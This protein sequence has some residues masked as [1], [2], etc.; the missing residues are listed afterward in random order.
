MGRGSCRCCWWSERGQ[1]VP[2]SRGLTACWSSSR[3]NGRGLLLVGEDGANPQQICSARTR[4]AGARNPVW[5]PDGSEIA[6]SVRHQ[7]S[8]IYADGSCFACSLP[9][10]F[11][12]NG[13]SVPTFDPGFLPDGRLVV[14]TK[15]DDIPGSTGPRLAAMMTDGANVAQPLS[16]LAAAGVVRARTASRRPARQTQVSGVRDRSPHREGAPADPRWRQLAELVTGW[17]SLGGRRR[18]LD[19]SGLLPR[20]ATQAPD[21]R[22]GARMGAERQRACVRRCAPP[23]VRDHRPG[24]SAPRRRSHS[25]RAG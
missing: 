19:C 18:W 22:R 16:L 20:E 7:T 11:D 6:A 13:N 8:V 4:C 10:P 14:S 15:G 24:W 5:S 2:R 21:P 1:R 25:R 3:H 12:F 23:P 9:E 17:P